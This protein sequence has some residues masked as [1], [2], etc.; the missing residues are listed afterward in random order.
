[1]GASDTPRWDGG[2][3]A[4]VGAIM[5]RRSAAAA[6]AATEADPEMRAEYERIAGDAEEEPRP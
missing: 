4:G 2:G 1:V 6:L 5:I 3:R